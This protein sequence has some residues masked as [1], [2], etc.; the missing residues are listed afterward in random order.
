MLKLPL[1][2]FTMALVNGLSAQ[3]ASSA[4]ENG[5]DEK[6][7]ANRKVEIKDLTDEDKKNQPSNVTI[8]GKS[9][10]D[11][12]IYPNQ[13]GNS[14]TISYSTTSWSPLIIYIYDANGKSVYMETFNTK[15]LDVKKTIWLNG[16]SSGVY[17]VHLSQGGQVETKKIVLA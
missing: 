9:F 13:E 11:M 17:Y 4:N 7:W 2:V 1:I 5:K 3:K 15:E 8:T 16:I 12:L 6:T 14:I 10:S